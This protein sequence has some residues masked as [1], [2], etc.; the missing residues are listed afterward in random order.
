MGENFL[1]EWT[2]PLSLGL[3]LEHTVGVHLDPQYTFLWNNLISFHIFEQK[4]ASKLL[5]Y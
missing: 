1:S 2:T 5:L 3:T 4:N